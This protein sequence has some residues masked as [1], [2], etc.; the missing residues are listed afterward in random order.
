MAWF[1]ALALLIPL[2]ASLFWYFSA[3]NE[4]NK[5]VSGLGFS[6]GEMGSS[7][8]AE[9]YRT[10]KAG[11]PIGFIVSLTASL[12]GVFLLIVSVIRFRSYRELLG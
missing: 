1:S 10:I 3:M 8:F 5:M 6:P 4:V 9:S 2:G 12:P 11:I 7:E